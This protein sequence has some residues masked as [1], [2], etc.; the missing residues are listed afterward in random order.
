MMHRLLILAM[1]AAVALSA[2]I[3]GSLPGASGPFSD[4][5]GPIIFRLL[6]APGGAALKIS[7]RPLAFEPRGK[8][9]PAGGIEVDRCQDGSR[10]QVLPILAASP[11]AFPPQTVDINFDGYLDL[12]VVADHGSKWGRFLWWVYDPNTAS[13]VH[14]ELT[15]Q[16]GQLTMNNFHTDPKR[17]E[18]VTDDLMAGCPNLITRYRIDANRLVKVH[19]EIGRQNSDNGCTVSFLDL[20]GGTMRTSRMQ[21]F[22]EGKPLK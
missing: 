21:R 18:F 2:E 9:V 3:C 8:D 22:Y 1:C 11:V 13:F 15:R 6:V 20:V 17:H 7:V 12:G 14:T 19:Q 4:S 5:D 10:V 16:L